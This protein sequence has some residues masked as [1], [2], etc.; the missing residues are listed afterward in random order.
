MSCSKDR[1]LN[2]QVVYFKLAD[3]K[4]FNWQTKN[5]YFSKTEKELLKSVPNY[6]KGRFLEVGCGEGGNLYLLNYNGSLIFGLDNCFEKLRF[7]KT[8]LLNVNFI[9]A[10]ALNMPWKSASFDVILCRD[11]LHHILDKEKIIKE[12]KR[13][14]KTDGKILFVEANGANPIMKSFALFEKAERGMIKNTPMRL[15]SLLSKHFDDIYI[16]MYQPFPIFRVVLHYK[17]GLSYLG[18]LR[19]V[20]FLFDPL[21][22]IFKWLIP[23]YRWAYSVI[24]VKC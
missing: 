3:E 13:I 20:K 7:A 8:K 15:K 23:Y 11:V 10:D 18:K 5:K 17:Y 19:L 24:L 22:S 1:F 12:I 21:N 6:K 9:C 16:E 2:R 4:K 14:C